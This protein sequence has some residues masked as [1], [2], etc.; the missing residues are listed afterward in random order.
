MI[1][2]PPPLNRTYNRHPNIQGI[3]YR[4]YNRDCYVKPQK[5]ARSGLHDLPL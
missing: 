1:K 3:G 5:R 2:K 4:D